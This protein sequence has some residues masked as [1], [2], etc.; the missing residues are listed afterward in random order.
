MAT[1]NDE[2]LVL[3]QDVGIVGATATIR[4]N[5]GQRLAN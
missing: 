5:R 2:E 1:D 3:F 4:L